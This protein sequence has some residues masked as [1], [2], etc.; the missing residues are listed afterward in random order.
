MVQQNRTHLFSQKLGSGA[1]TH[2]A[3]TQHAHTYAQ[4][5][6]ETASSAD[7]VTSNRHRRQV[8]HTSNRILPGI[9]THLGA[10]LDSLTQT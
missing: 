10:T 8:L 1:L 5:R 9:S 6:L 7:A 2:F 4:M 3:T